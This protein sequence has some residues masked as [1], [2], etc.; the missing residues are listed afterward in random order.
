MDLF[1]IK[2]LPIVEP[3]IKFTVNEEYMQENIFQEEVRT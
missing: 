3:E 2:E 1:E